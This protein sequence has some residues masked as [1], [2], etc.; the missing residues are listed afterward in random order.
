MI[1]CIQCEALFDSSHAFDDHDCPMTPEV[2]DG[3]SWEDF[4][5]RADEYR[6]RK[7]DD[8]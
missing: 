8:E 1:R 3:E 2:L 7:L 4:K 6:R 5:V